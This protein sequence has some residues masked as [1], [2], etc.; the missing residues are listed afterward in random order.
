MYPEDISVNIKKVINIY[1]KFYFSFQ[2]GTH[3]FTYKH[4]THIN[5]S[6]V[7][8]CI[9]F[10]NAQRSCD[11]MLKDTAWRVTCLGQAD[12]SGHRVGHYWHHHPLHLHG[13]GAKFQTPCTCCLAPLLL[14]GKYSRH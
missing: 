11:R 5:M 14:V 1:F 4:I 13:L 3:Q 12:T 6:S 7:G 2:Y 8:S 9:A 10:Q